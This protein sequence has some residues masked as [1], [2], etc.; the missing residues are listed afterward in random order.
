ML[1]IVWHEVH[2]SP[3]QVFRI[4]R[5]TFSVPVQVWIEASFA[6]TGGEFQPRRFEGVV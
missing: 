5:H 4:E 6:I 2:C 1:R 3:F